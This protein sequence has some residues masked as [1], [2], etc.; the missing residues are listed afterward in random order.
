MVGLTPGGGRGQ[1][2]ASTGG[3]WRIKVRAS[4]Y[5]GHSLSATNAGMLLPASQAP[6]W[7]GYGARACCGDRQTWIPLLPSYSAFLSGCRTKGTVHVTPVSGHLAQS[8]PHPP[9]PG[10]HVLPQA[11][12]PPVL[13]GL[14]QNHPPESQAR[15][16]PHHGLGSCVSCR[17]P[18]PAGHQFMY[19]TETV[20]APG[21]QGYCWTQKSQ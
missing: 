10:G 7:R 20:K 8:R 6:G 3:T 13:R 1:G 5:I 19:K 21:S 15:R 17:L 9:Q 18:S 14:I 12:P 16:V 2:Q 4:Q 11:S